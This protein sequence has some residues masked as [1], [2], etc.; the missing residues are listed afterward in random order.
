L[1][2]LGLSQTGKEVKLMKYEKPEL[3]ILGSAVEVIQNTS[4]KTASQFDSS[5]LDNTAVVAA[6][7]IDE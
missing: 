1:T 4:I 6:Y 2:Q 5:T 7:D 3:S